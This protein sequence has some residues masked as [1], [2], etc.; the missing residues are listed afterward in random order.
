MEQKQNNQT[1]IVKINK[2]EG[3]LD[4]L[5]HL[6]Q[7]TK[8]DI[9]DIS[10]SEITNQ[11]LEYLQQMHDLNLE[12]ASEY[13]LMSAQL[14]EIKSRLLLPKQVEEE[15]NESD[16]KNELIA[17]LLEYKKYKEVMP[18]LRNLEEQRGNFFI[19]G[20]TDLQPLIKK[21][22]ILDIEQKRDV[23]H[24][25]RAFD[26][27]MA[28][29]KLAVHTK[30]VIDKQEITI[31]E[32]MDYLKKHIKNQGVLH[33]STCFNGKGRSY[34]VTTFLALLQ[35]VRLHEIV[36]IQAHNFSDVEIYAT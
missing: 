17:R 6:I 16:P 26:R 24:L 29:R 14:I 22:I 18:T 3:P 5:L 4:L 10:I 13:L 7:K 21:E 35:L 19:K 1:Y 25:V 15:A 11:Y 9:L 27:L 23:Y 8:V 36:V 32:Q 30:A 34:I 12:I 20:S 33:L 31:E 28:N 2:F